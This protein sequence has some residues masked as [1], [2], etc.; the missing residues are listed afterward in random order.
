M[1]KKVLLIVLIML[2]VIS[3]TPIEVS[4]NK[5][6]KNI[7]VSGR[8]AILMDQTSGRVLFSKNIHKQM[9]IASIT[10]V[11]TAILAIESGKMDE[12]VKVSDN[13]YGTEG[14]SLYLKKGEKIKLKDLV[15]GL[16]LKSGNDA[17]VAIAEKVGGSV[18]GF[19]HLMNKKAREL[20]MFDSH[21]ANPNG[22]DT[23][24]D[25]YSTA[26]DMAILTKYAM[27]N[28][29]FRRIFKTKHYKAP[30]PNDKW[31]RSWKNKNKLLFNYDYSTGG[32]TGYT[33]RAGRT[34]I[35]TATKDDMDL[36]VVTLDDGN[37]WEDHRNLFNWG[38]KT[39]DMVTIVEKGKISGIEKQAYKD[40]L[41]THRSLVYPLTDKE[42]ENLSTHLKLYKFDEASKWPEHEP[43]GYLNVESGDEALTRMPLFMEQ[44]EQDESGGFWSLFKKLFTSSLGW[45]GS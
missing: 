36:V 15:Y 43:I 1:S 22:L 20:G 2:L 32:K 4:A 23:Q 9:R 13:A 27:S 19:V 7:S 3:S 41:Y 29:T 45:I 39:Y 30:N 24:E 33:K 18:Q 28:K 34:L 25:H 6:N 17:A 8:A 37:D 21:F 44:V 38:F 35:S 31:D 16:M 12:M 40:R 14:S 10:K 42:N 11:M 26:Y 5:G